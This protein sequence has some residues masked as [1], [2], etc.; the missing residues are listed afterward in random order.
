MNNLQGIMSGQAELK[1]TYPSAAY[2]ALQ[3][4]RGKLMESLKK[5]ADVM[6]NV[7]GQDAMAKP[8]RELR[9]KKV[10]A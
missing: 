1:D 10:G 4:R 5:K 3:R 2:D 8:Q 7:P 9:P 6:T